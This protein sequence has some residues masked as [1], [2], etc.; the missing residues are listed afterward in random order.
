MD[1]KKEIF[2]LIDKYYKENFPKKSFVPGESPIAVSGKVFDQTELK[3]LVEASLDGWFTSGRFTEQFEKKLSE[4]IDVE[5]LLTTNSGSSANLLAVAALTVEDLGDRRLKPGDEVITVASAFPTTVNPL[6]TYGL[7]PVFVDIDIPTYN[8]DVTKI[9]KAITDKTKAIVIAHTL[10]N[11]FNIKAVQAICQKHNLWLIEDCCDSLGSYYENK[12]V[13]TFGDIGTLSF[14]PA[15]HITTG[16]GGALFTNNKALKKIIGSLRD[17]GRDCWCETGCDNSCEKR[18]EWKFENLP[19]AY[20]HKYV[21]SRLGYNL[22]ITDMQAALGLAQL[23]K[24]PDFIEIRKRNFK[25][26][27]EGLSKFKDFL[28]LPEAEMHSDPSWFGFLITVKKESV[29]DRRKIIAG[30]EERKIVTRLLF[31]GDIRKQPYFKNQIYKS[32]GETPNTDLVL[33][34]T[35]WIGVTPLITEEMIKYII[36]SFE[37]I[38]VNCSVVHS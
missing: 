14:Y 2:S 35:F 5:Y 1:T 31:A 32:V 22:K 13:G 25:L 17:W 8:I 12:H 36:K 37:E 38:F 23:E 18:F 24:L 4:F 34:N 27:Y 19:E 9:E 20:D 7:V 3:F 26:L 21:Y 30:L 6:L 15:H 10:G 33:N 28:I 11:P 29:A 16:E